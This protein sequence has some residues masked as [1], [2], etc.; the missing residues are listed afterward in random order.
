MYLLCW[1]ASPLTLFASG[2]D[3]DTETTRDRVMVWSARLC[4]D[5]GSRKRY[6]RMNVSRASRAKKF[7]PEPLRLG[8]GSTTVAE[9]VGGLAV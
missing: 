8:A 4:G 1:N 9:N 3:D 6:T 7:L 2:L 5:G